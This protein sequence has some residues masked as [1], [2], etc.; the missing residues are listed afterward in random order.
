[1]AFN[2]TDMYDWQ[3]LYT[4]E[5]K[6][7]V[8]A[9]FIRDTMEPQ[10]RYFL[11]PR[12]SWLVKRWN[13]TES[14]ANIYVYGGLGAARKGDLTELAVEGAVEADYETRA[15]YFSGKAQIVAAR[16][17]NTLAI[18]QARAGFAPYLGESGELHSWLVGQVQYFPFA[19]DQSLRVGPVLRMFYRNVLWEFGVSTHGS[20]NFNFMA[21][22]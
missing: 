19:P 8:G 10:E 20:W 16:N 13:E 5:P 1:M 2:Q 3:V 4:F 15:V 9:D 12:L 21:H 7:S 18:Y 11:I 22:W 17:F 6:L 14:Q